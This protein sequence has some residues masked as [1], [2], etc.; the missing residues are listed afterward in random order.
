MDAQATITAKSHAFTLK[1]QAASL[2]VEF[3]FALTGWPTDTPGEIKKGPLGH[4]FLYYVTKGFVEGP[5]IRGQIVSPSGDWAT[6]A[7][8]GTLMLD[9]RLALKTDD[10]VD[11][12]MVY[13]GF[14]SSDLQKVHVGGLFQVSD[15]K[16]DWLNKVLYVGV[17][18]YNPDGSLTYYFYALA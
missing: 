7:D 15:E 6:L 8:D 3:L 1:D 18:G 11:I 13:Q 16:Y 12:L 5:R 4:R 9:V 14:V 10:N 2:P 17:G